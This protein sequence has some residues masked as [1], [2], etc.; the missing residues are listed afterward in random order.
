MSPRSPKEVFKNFQDS[1]QRRQW[2]AAEQDFFLLIE[3]LEDRPDLVHSVLNHTAAFC[4]R[5]LDIW[6]KML[7][8]ADYEPDD[9]ALRRYCGLKRVLQQMAR[10]CGRSLHSELLP[11]QKPTGSLDQ[12]SPFSPAFRKFII[13]A[14][15]NDL[16]P[17]RVQQLQDLPNSLLASV[18][19]A[20]LAEGFFNSQNTN[21]VK[22]SI[23]E[24][25]KKN[26]DWSLKDTSHRSFL[27]I[28]MGCSYW[29]HPAKHD[30]KKLLNRRIEEF[31]AQK[32][33]EG[34]QP[35]PVAKSMPRPRVLIISER[36]SHNHAMHR[37]YGPSIGA[38]RENFEI[39]LM[40]PDGESDAE[41]EALCDVLDRTPFVPS[42]P[43]GFIN[44][45]RNYKADIAYFPSVGMRLSGVFTA[46]ARVAP[47][48]I[49]TNGH[50]A[51]TLSRHIDYMVL[52]D[53][54]FGGEAFF[55][56]RLL[57]R[58]KAPHYLANTEGDAPL[59]DIR[60]NPDVIK[61]AVPAWVLKLSPE[62]LDCCKHIADA[63]SRKIEFHFFPNATGLEADAC[64]A[65]LQALVPSVVH[66]RTSYGP[67][68]ANLNACDIHLSSFP[69]GCANGIVDSAL[70]GLPMVNMF[71]G[72]PHAR[73]D[74]NLV[75]R[76]NQPS[77]LS[78]DTPEEYISAVL[79]LVDEDLLRVQISKD[80]LACSP[81]NHFFTSNSNQVSDFVQIFEL[82]LKHHNTINKGHARVWTLQD[83]QTLG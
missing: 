62:F 39:I 27:S 47:V 8:A 42:D 73:I 43:R 69:F 12:A 37:C 76:L 63:S 30:I 13:V 78:V 71:G 59:P 16:T 75:N 65:N 48:Q 3:F 22:D 36:Y 7:R 49:A 34:F 56:E 23:V 80:I 21:A 57:L 20:F 35:R 77:W 44:A 10:I 18:A 2:R 29:S 4:G 26:A 82:A 61:L 66:Y 81:G 31:L 15:I 14:S 55:S 6:I 79:R 72:E 74:A 70:L 17:K 60:H 83:L 67:Y 50:P 64:K 40:L 53:E 32:G 68:M 33:L 1:V 9:V 28:W 51:T 19:T 58:P 38:L 11:Q 45:A 5:A 25:L 54:V 46:N 24:L 52:V 41:I